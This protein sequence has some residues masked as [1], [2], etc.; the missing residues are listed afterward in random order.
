ARRPPAHFDDDERARRT[1]VDRH[2]IEL[3]TP[4]MDVPGQDGPTGL[5][6]SAEHQRFGGV[7]CLLS[8][9][10]CRSGDRTFHAD[11]LTTRPAPSHIAVCTPAYHRGRWKRSDRGCLE[12]EQ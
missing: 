10:P 4:D 11:I 6:Q 3:V 8:A 9:R 2:E 12:R 1:R 7:T 5:E